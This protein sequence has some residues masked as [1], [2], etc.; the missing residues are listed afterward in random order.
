MIVA[1]GLVAAIGDV[2][3]FPDP[4][5]LVSYVGL[6][7]G[8]AIRPRTCSAWSHQ[9]TRTFSCARHAGR[10]RLGCLQSARPPARVL[11]AY[12][13]PAWPSDRG[14]RRGAQA[15]RA[16]LA[17]ADQGCRLT[18]GRARHWSRTSGPWSCKPANR[19]GKAT[20]LERPMLTMLRLCAIGRSS[21][22][23]ML[24]MPT[25]GLSANGSRGAAGSGARV[26]QTRNDTEGYVVGLASSSPALCHAVTR[27]IAG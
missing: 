24:S 10:G 12:P 2:R 7:A 18:N 6:T 23:V 15:G 25:N 9:Q 11:F 22:P 17:S 8:T 1:A 20:S 3:R 14:R 19:L 4:Q 16:L 13:H 5:K 21:W 27:A 26:P